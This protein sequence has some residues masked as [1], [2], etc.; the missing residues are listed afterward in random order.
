MS[1]NLSPLRDSIMIVGGS[2]F[3]GTTRGTQ[4]PLYDMIWLNPETLDWETV[5]GQLIFDRTENPSIA[6]PDEYIQC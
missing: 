2:N 6:L 1:D 5:P 3:E 4:N